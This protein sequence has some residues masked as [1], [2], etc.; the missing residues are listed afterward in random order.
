MTQIVDLDAIVPEDVTFSFRGKKYLLPGDLDV[1]HTYKLLRCFTA[2]GKAEQGDDLG[3]RERAETQL[4]DALLE[5]FRQRDPE[6]AELPFGVKGLQ[7]VLIEVLKA[8]GLEIQSGGE[9]PP[10]KPGP[11]RSRPS[12]RSPRSAK[13]SGSATPRR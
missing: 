9:G 5:L 10:T 8:I 1:E 11:K 13:S 6:L 12:K 2:A 4:R 3:K 7:I